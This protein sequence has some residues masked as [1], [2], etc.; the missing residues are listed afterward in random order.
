MYTRAA[1]EI[2]VAAETRLVCADVGS[3]G[4]FHPRLEALEDRIHLLGFDA[5]PAECERL[6]LSAAPGRRHI[7]AAVG[8]EGERCIVSLHKKRK[9]SS[10]YETDQERIR[11]FDDPER[12]A[13]EA[14]LA[15]TTRS[16]D[17]I[18]RD[19]KIE[20]IDALKADVEGHELAVLQGY[21]GPFMLAEVETTIFPFRKQVPLLDEIM[22]HM[23]S[24][25][26]VMID[27]RRTFWNPTASRDIDESSRG[28]LIYGDA[29]FVRDPFN[30]STLEL[31]ADRAAVARYLALLCVYGYGGIALMALSQFREKQ[32][33]TAADGSRFEDLLRTHCRHSLKMGQIGPAWVRRR[34]GKW[35]HPSTAVP[36]ITADPEVG[37]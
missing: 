10:I 6:N 22:S 17:S 19:E 30:P 21:S 4:G 28:I 18:C 23:K 3:A 36:F 29:L 14:T 31:M 12:L 34:I 20:R 27:L 5:D 33:V 1:R 35:V 16:L 32:K 2:L 15:F 25:G 26:F 24:K 11:Y 13:T 9:T 8:R 37:N 7:N